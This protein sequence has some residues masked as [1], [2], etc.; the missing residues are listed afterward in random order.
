MNTANLLLDTADAE[1][2]ANSADTW[3]KVVVQL[4]SRAMPPVNLPRPD[5]ATYDAVATWLADEWPW[6][7]VDRPGR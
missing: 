4:R 5:N 1:Q 3:E 6:E 2:V 7:R